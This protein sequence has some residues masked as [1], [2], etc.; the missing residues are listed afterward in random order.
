[1]KIAANV[2]GGILVLVGSVWILQGINVLPGSFMTGQIQYAILGA[3]L[4]VGGLALL[5]Y[6][7]RRSRA[8]KG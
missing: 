1:M 5:L 2:L 3:V 7:N 4:G 8:G 6:T